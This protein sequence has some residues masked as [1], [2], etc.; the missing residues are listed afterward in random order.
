MR[1]S[2]IALALLASPS[3]LSSCRT[4]PRRH[5]AVPALEVGEPFRPPQPRGPHEV[6]G[7]ERG[8]VGYGKLI[9]RDKTRFSEPSI[10][11]REHLHNLRLVG[12]APGRHL[13]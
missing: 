10:K 8:N 9:A 6:D 1:V 13:R 3:S 5:L 7:H 4:R 11:K 2:Q 12:F